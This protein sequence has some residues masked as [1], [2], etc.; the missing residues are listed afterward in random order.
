M[1]SAYTG[2]DDR[3]STFR[4][5]M[6]IGHGCELSGFSKVHAIAFT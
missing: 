6:A 5:H 2:M 4:V 1:F 3:Q